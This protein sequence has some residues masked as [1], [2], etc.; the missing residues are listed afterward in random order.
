[1]NA[2]PTKN[3]KAQSKSSRH[4]LRVV[5]GVV[6]KVFTL[7]LGTIIVRCFCHWPSLLF[8]YQP[9]QCRAHYSLPPTNPSSLARCHL[10]THKNLRTKFS[11][12]KI[13]I[14]WNVRL[15][16]WPKKGTLPILCGL[17]RLSWGS[18]SQPLRTIIQSSS[19]QSFHK[20]FCQREI[21]CTQRKKKFFKKPINLVL[22]NIG[23]KAYKTLN[24]QGHTVHI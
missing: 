17:N 11:A 20:L 7:E 19:F 13:A 3:W 10:T 21:R 16:V 1:M 5:R 14:N 6:V 8:S 4:S 2:N 18:A 15:R 9:G 22:L 23:F 24:V 12:I